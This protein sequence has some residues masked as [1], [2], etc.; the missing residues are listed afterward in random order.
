[1]SPAE[2][3]EASGGPG[4][5]PGGRPLVSV[6]IPAYNE[7]GTIGTLLRKVLDSPLG[8]Q[9]EVIVVDDGSVD[10]TAVQAEAFRAAGVRLVRH[11]RN[12]G[13]GAALRTGFK[14]A[15]GSIIIVQ[16]ADLEYDP[17]NYQALVQPVLD[18]R[19][20]V[21]Y[22][23]RFLGGPHRV[24]YFWHYVANRILTL[25]S[26]MFSNLNLS[27]M[28]TG[29]KVFRREVLEGLK[30]R[31]RRFGIEPELTQKVARGGWRVFEVPI[32]YY[33]R[34]YEEGKKIRALDALRAIWCVVRYALAD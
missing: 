28:E 7:A 23:S 17:E 16:D 22:G 5:A 15:R 13:K 20:D 29:Y 33:G 12:L 11:E 18:G 24:L 10:D 27:D 9:M 19:A 34:T 3:P 25:W 6:V 21:V 32:S 14:A 26:N 8:R 31:E 4:R 30:L 1:V 2:Q